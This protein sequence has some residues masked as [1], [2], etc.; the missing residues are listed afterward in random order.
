[1]TVQEMKFK[2][3]DQNG[4]HIGYEYHEPNKHGVI[5]IYHLSLRGDWL[6]DNMDKRLVREGFFIPHF[7]KEI[8]A[9]NKNL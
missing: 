7:S 2:L 5:Q 6:K 8:V 4:N 3:F 1:M 9:K